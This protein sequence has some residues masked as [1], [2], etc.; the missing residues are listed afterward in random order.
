MPNYGLYSE[1]GLKG[2]TAI[3]TN[4]RVDGM[5]WL[6]GT[7]PADTTIDLTPHLGKF[8][9]TTLKFGENSINLQEIRNSYL[10][11]LKDIFESN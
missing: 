7:D 9:G 3:A 11:K 10:S 1:F 2:D 6:S 8:T 5:V 4:R